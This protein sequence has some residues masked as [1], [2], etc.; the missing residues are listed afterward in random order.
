MPVYD[1]FDA[2]MDQYKRTPLHVAALLERRVR[3]LV[4]AGNYDFIC[5][6]VGNERWTKE[7]EWSG[8]DKFVREPLR[9]WL[10]DGVKAGVTRNFGGFTFATIEGG[11]HMASSNGSTARVIRASKEMAVRK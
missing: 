11:G 5:N 9:E 1:A 4:Y 10:I 3:V 6:W 2:Q 8:Q 7:L